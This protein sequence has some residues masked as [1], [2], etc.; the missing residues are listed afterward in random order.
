MDEKERIS[1]LAEAITKAYV[2]LDHGDIEG[3]Q[4]ELFMALPV[5]DYPDHKCE[6]MDKIYNEVVRAA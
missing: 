5:A 1:G 6:M 4:D 3:A 2:L